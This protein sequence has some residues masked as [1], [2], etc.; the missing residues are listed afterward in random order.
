MHCHAE[1]DNETEY[2]MRPIFIYAIVCCRLPLPRA[3]ALLLLLQTLPQMT[4][5]HQ[6]AV[7]ILFQ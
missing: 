2:L 6:A 1:T 7:S 5:F 3:P 4:T